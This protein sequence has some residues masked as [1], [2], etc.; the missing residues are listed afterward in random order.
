MNLWRGNIY[1]RALRAR[2]GVTVGHLP[3]KLLIT[4]HGV[5]EKGKI[6]A[7]NESMKHF[8]EITHRMTGCSVNII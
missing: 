5:I 4:T 8:V 1:L 7:I 3:G 2:E 6:G